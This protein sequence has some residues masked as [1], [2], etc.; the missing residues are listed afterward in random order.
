M[1]PSG[2][3]FYSSDR[4]AD[5]RNNLFIGSLSGMHIVQ[6]VIDNNLVVGEESLLA[7]ERQDAA[8]RFKM[9][10]KLKST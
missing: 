8:E 6:L 1:S 4:I 3:T 5:W 10:N 2:M 7:N 9:M